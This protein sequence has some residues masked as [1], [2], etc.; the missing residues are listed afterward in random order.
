MISGK[1]R[2]GD[3]FEFTQSFFSSVIS[4]HSGISD[5]Q[6][7]VFNEYQNLVNDIYKITKKCGSLTITPREITLKAASAVKVYDGRK[8]SAYEYS[9]TEGSLAVGDAIS[10]CRIEGSQYEIGYSDNIITGVVI[11]N[12]YNDVVTN[13]YIIKLE[14]GTL[15]VLPQN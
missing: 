11:R 3:T 6:V 8:L 14:P 4:V 9:I 7:Y 2:E 10:S 5:F 12:Y 1:L 13:N 15:Q